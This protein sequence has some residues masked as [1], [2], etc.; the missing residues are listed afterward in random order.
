MPDG[1][2]EARAGRPRT[3]AGAGLGPKP[4]RGRSTCTEPSTP[5]LPF[6]FFSR[7]LL[8]EFGLG[9]WRPLHFPAPLNRLY[10]TEAGPRKPAGPDGQTWASRAPAGHADSPVARAA[11]PWTGARVPEEQGAGAGLGQPG[12]RGPA[13]LRGRGTDAPTA[14]HAWLGTGP[15]HASARAWPSC[16]RAAPA[17]A[18]PR[19]RPQAVA[20]RSAERARSR[21]LEAEHSRTGHRCRDGMATVQAAGWCRRRGP[22]RGVR[23]PEHHGGPARSGGIHA[24]PRPLALTRKDSSK[25]RSRR[26]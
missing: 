22:R 5:A 4:A 23:T 14:R 1:D 9:T 21:W 11:W 2:T 12:A 16:M 7:P 13:V 20:E 18:R 24:R 19:P 6:S 10:K 26:T 25:R 15:A 3:Q 8:S 17:A